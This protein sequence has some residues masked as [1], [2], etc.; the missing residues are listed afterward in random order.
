MLKSI[1]PVWFLITISGWLAGVFVSATEVDVRLFDAFFLSSNALTLLPSAIFGLV[2]SFLNYKFSKLRFPWFWALAL[3]LFSNAAIQWVY[4]LIWPHVHG[5]SGAYKTVIAVTA[6]Y[7]WILIPFS[8]TVAF[9]AM[10]QQRRKEADGKLFLRFFSVPMIVAAGVCIWMSLQPKPV[11]IQSLDTVNETSRTCCGQIFKA[12][13]DKQ[14]NTK[15]GLIATLIR[16]E[17]ICESSCPM[18]SE[19]VQACRN[20][21]KACKEAEDKE[22]CRKRNTE[23]LYSCSIP[24]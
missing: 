15:N 2:Y 8:I 1:L 18:L 16:T 9:L 21:I 17:Q 20:R 7:A 14:Y 23:C 22:T 3:G 4:F 13:L 6:T 11:E 10:Y 19:C 12:L 24:L 5:R